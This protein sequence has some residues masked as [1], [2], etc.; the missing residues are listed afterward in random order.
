MEFHEDLF[1]CASDLN[2]R[3]HSICL[4]C[5]VADDYR[6]RLCETRIMKLQM[7]FFIRNI[8]LK[9]YNSRF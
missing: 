7:Y 1:S 3:F 8:V 9:D 2:V 5:E 6:R 4:P